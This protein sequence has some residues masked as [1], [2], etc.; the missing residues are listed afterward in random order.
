MLSPNNTCQIIRLPPMIT[1]N[2]ISHPIPATIL[3]NPKARVLAGGAAPSTWRKG[4][5]VGRFVVMASSRLDHCSSFIS[6]LD[7]SY[8]VVSPVAV[9]RSPCPF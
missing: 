1:T 4:T 7:L 8:P 6:P 5:A 9:R 3:S 2:A